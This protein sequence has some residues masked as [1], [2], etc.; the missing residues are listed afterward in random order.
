M[1]NDIGNGPRYQNP[2]NRNADYGVCEYDLRQNFVASLVAVSPKFENRLMNIVAGDWQLSPIISAHGGFPFNPTLGQD[3]SRTAE[4]VDRPN[5]V[6]DP[7][8]R[9]LKTRVWLN[10][11]AFAAPPVGSFG[12][13][14]W[15]S[16]RGP[17]FFDMDVSLSRWFTVHESHRLQLRFEFFNVTNHVNFNNPS[18]GL[19]VAT[20]GTILGA[21]NPRI[22]QFA[23]KYVF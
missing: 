17:G 20:F 10:T 8:V 14:G 3:N 12:N 16:L 23:A 6:G 13:A 1:V 18:S 21:G 2:L 7:Y 5:I 19:N 4:G 15:N 11:S 9:N 22:L